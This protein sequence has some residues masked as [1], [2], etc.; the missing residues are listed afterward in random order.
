MDDREPH[1]AAMNCEQNFDE[2]ITFDFIVKPNT[3]IISN[4]PLEP[5]ADTRGMFGIHPAGVSAACHCRKSS[6]HHGLENVSL[7]SRHSSV[8]AANT[9]SAD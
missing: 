4:C 5:H 6:P 8:F 9:A 1:I 2:A 3:T 7:T